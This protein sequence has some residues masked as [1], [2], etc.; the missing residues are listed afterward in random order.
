MSRLTDPL[1]VSPVRWGRVLLVVALA[2]AVA[3]LLDPLAWAHVRD[4]RVNE[5]EWGRL[6]RSAGYVPTWILGA[7]AIWLAGRHGTLVDGTASRRAAGWR[8]TTLLLAP[9]L[10]GGL[11]ELVK[12]VVR[13]QRPGADSAAYLFRPYDVDFWSTRGLGL[14]SSHTAVAF[15]AAAVMSRL[16]PGSAPV[17]YLLATGCA[18]TRIMA[19]AHYLSD[20][21]A[22]AAIGWLVAEGC[23]RWAARRVST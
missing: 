4:P 6:L 2:L 18:V 8:A 15:G 11:A 14:A 21:V 12:I 19:G 23:W 13:R 22:A 5:R 1:A 17:W 16:L 3:H 9:A 7:A 10:A 20:T